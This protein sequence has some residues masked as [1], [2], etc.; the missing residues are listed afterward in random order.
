MLD[1]I[2]RNPL[3]L[4]AIAVFLALVGIVSVFISRNA[5]PFISPQNAGNTKI[6]TQPGTTNPN[7]TISAKNTVDIKNFSFSISTLTVKKGDTVTWT[8]SDSSVHTA[9]ADDGTFDTG[10]IN[11]GSSQTVTFTKSGTYTYHCSVHP[12]MKGTIV[13]Q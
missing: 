12:M 3:I 8:N 11:P 10:S 2:R 1:N 7:N 13:V 4:G 6:E 9:T 5:G